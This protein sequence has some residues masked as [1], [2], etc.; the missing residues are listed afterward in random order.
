M[1][2]SGQQQ[3]GDRAGGGDQHA[4]ATGAA[5]V[6]DIDFQR[7]GP[8][9]DRQAAEKQK[10]RQQRTA[11]PVD[12][13]EGIVRRALPGRGFGVAE[14]AGHPDAHLVVDPKGKNNDG[15]I[16]PKK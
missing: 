15:E 3:V 7:P 4:V 14:A 12:A 8:A 6:L 16:Q 1:P 9:Q 11:D 2:D 10:Q 13:G 5:Q